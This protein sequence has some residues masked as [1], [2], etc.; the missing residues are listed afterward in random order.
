[1]HISLEPSNA[2]MNSIL[3][4]HIFAPNRFWCDSGGNKP[5]TAKKWVL[6]AFKGDDSAIAKHFAALSTNGKSVSEFGMTREKVGLAIKTRLRK[7]CN[8][9]KHCCTIYR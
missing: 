9:L 4:Y 6:D 8:K 5:G 7:R 1:M 3:Q 2:F